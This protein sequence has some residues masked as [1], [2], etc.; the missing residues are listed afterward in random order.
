VAFD[1]QE[2]EGRKDKRKR[3]RK[4]GMGQ[5]ANEVAELELHVC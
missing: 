1:V 5:V 3:K 2:A 4:T